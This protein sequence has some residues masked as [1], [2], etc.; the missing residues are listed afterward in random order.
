M[1]LP[2]EHVGEAVLTPAGTLFTGNA[3]ELAGAGAADRLRF[4][5]GRVGG[6]WP[7]I[8]AGSLRRRNGA[9][10]RQARLGTAGH[11]VVPPRLAGGAFVQFVER[12]RPN[13]RWPRA[14]CITSYC[15]DVMWP[16]ASIQ[17]AALWAPGICM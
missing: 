16:M 8:R 14:R 5:G 9:D 2:P 6:A 12:P 7:Q 15:T 13:G 3:D 17:Y 1:R 11:P 4:H 10:S